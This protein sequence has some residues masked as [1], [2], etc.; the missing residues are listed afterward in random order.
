MF[1][2]KMSSY[3]QG[4][5][6]IRSEVTLGFSPGT[7]SLI[8]F[9]YCCLLFSPKRIP[10]KASFKT[11]VLQNWFYKRI[12]DIIPAIS[13]SSGD[14][15]LKHK[16]FYTASWQVQSIKTRNRWSQLFSLLKLSI[17]WI[18]SILSSVINCWYCAVVLSTLLYGAETR[19][20]NQLQVKKAHAYMMCHLREIMNIIQTEW[21]WRMLA[22]HLWL[23]F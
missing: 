19:T 4:E 23:I 6:N 2:K 12:Q 17:L 5:S 18:S 9:S 8:L 22:F 21:F 10:Q 13:G 16:P 11:H 20:I 7:S 15:H 14:Y 1:H 3:F